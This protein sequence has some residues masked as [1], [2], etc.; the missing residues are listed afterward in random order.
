MTATTRARRHLAVGTAAAA[1]T[2]IAVAVTLLLPPAVSRLPPVPRDELEL[3]GALHVHTQRS[4]GAGTVDEVAAAAAAAGLQFV[5]L[6]DHGDATRPADPPR[7]LS[8]VLC[9]DGVEVGSTAGHYLALGLDRAAPYP[10][11]GEPRDVVDDVRR[12]GGFG[13]VTHP[14]SPREALRWRAWS[15]PVDGLEWLNA[16][17]EWRD[18]SRRSLARALATYFFRP[19]EVIASLFDRPAT[20][21]RWDALSQ[22]RRVMAVAGHDAHARI[23]LSRDDEPAAD[24][25]A[26]RLPSYAAM[27]RAFAQRVRLVEPMK[28]DAR[29][30][31]RLVLRALQAGHGYT[32][33][34]AYASPARLTFVIHGAVAMIPRLAE[35][36]AAFVGS[37]R[38]HVIPTCLEPTRYELAQHH[39]RD[40]RHLL[41]RAG[42]SDP[43]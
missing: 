29:L 25:F 24:E 3:I 28:G 1:G 2:T 41:H 21:E 42:L 32:V 36:A 30:D 40:H 8:G 14:D 19:P 38:V 13:I 7:Y 9:I 11:G 4:D 35:R 10:L 15:A 39:R 37:D 31:A 5:V 20:L 17:S 33:I 18:E 23:G 6:A 12:L 16:D 22:R 26:L 34:D 43:R 27:F